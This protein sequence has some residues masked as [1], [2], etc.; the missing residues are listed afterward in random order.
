MIWNPVNLAIKIDHYKVLNINVQR[1]KLKLK[2]DAT[3]QLLETVSRD[4]EKTDSYIAGDTSNQPC[5]IQV[6]ASI[7]PTAIL[8]L[9]TNG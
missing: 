5:P 3:R 1:N 7:K 4:V 6:T 9:F 8:F 2:W